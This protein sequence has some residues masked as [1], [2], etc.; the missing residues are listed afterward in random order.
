MTTIQSQKSEGR[1]FDSHS[2]H[3]QYFFDI[4]AIANFY[5]YIYI[6]FAHFLCFN[7]NSNNLNQLFCK[8][9]SDTE[10]QSTEYRKS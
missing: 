1:E 4:L 7:D 9:D 2:R 5:N 3:S 8:G 10:V 6:W